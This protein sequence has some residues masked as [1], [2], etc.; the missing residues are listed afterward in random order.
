M[1]SLIT[2]LRPVSL[3]G[4]GLIPVLEE[5]VADWSR[6]N[7]MEVEIAVA[8]E[9]TLPMDVEQAL[10]RVTQE[11]LSNVT[12]HSEAMKVE[13]QLRWEEN[14]VFLNISDNG[15]GFD[16]SAAEDQGMGLH[17]MRERMGALGGSLV[18]ESEPGKG[19][20]LTACCQISK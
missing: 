8:E 18:V 20:R 11:A 2:E 4:R 15:K 9:G 14:E 17:S 10:F 5:Y 13:I 12:R 1:A 6:Q 16:I 19:T 3:S 7:D